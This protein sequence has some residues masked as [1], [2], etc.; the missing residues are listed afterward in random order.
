VTT[1]DTQLASEPER[2]DR[3]PDIGPGPS[4]FWPRHLADLF[5]RPKSFFSRRLALGRM[6]N[7]LLVTWCY[8]I[9]NAIDHIG[10]EHFRAE[11][12]H[13]RPVWESLGPFVVESWVGFWLWALA[14]GALGGAIVWWIGGWWYG[15]L[16]RLSGARNPD[17]RLARMTLVYSSFVFGGPV[18]I[19]AVIQTIVYPNYAAAY[20]AGE[21]FSALLLLFLFWFIAT[22]YVGATT[23]FPV[24]RWKAIV[25][26]ILLPVSA[27]L[28]VY[29]LFAA[30][31]V[32]SGRETV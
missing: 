15:I 18:V 23:L 19:A 2:L 11:L 20:G 9:A 5:F 26:F 21:W 30:L 1:T 7:L 28:L 8:G 29:G 24:T 12:G 4:P 16:L 3:P 27:Y 32:F 14:A 31:F 22:S 25:W 6:P 17:K 10:R 13:P